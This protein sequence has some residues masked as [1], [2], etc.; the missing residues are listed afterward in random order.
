MIWLVVWFS[1]FLGGLN[2]KQND[3]W[4]TSSKTKIDFQGSYHTSVWIQCSCNKIECAIIFLK[5]RNNFVYL[6]GKW[7][8]IHI[9]L[10]Q[11]WWPLKALYS[12]VLHSPSHTHIHS[13]HLLAALCRSMRH[14][15][16]FSILLKDTSACRLFWEDWGSNCRPSG[17]RTTTLP[18]QPQL[19]IT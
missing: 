10:F 5:Q 8:C 7:I 14:N 4:I 9:V 2:W 3:R 19:S 16:G 11:S 15:Y 13:V 18:P 6:N 12:T 17:W 1:F